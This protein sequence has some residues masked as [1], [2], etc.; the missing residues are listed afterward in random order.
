MELD[1][2]KLEAQQALD[3]LFT[4]DA[5]PFK[6]TAHRIE[7]RAFDEVVVLFHDSRLHSVVVTCHA[8]ESFKQGVRAAVLK[9]ISN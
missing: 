4:E 2:L 8:D 5:L 6:L 7:I 9:Q 3:E 1:S